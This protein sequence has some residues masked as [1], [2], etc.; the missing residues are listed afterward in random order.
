VARAP[1]FFFPP[2]VNN[3]APRALELAA[4]VAGAGADEV[5]LALYDRMSPEPFRSPATER[6]RGGAG[7]AGGCGVTATAR[8]HAAPSSA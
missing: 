5:A 8:F 1:A 7:A 2:A 3:A 4:R 6:A